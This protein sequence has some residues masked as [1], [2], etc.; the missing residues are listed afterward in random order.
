MP[1]L[2]EGSAPDG[3]LVVAAS[4]PGVSLR[5]PDSEKHFHIV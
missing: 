4:S 2:P 1:G 5:E 3:G